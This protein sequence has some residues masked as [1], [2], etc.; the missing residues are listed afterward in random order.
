MTSILTDVKKMIG[1]DENYTQF[2]TDLIIHIN[3][4]LL[5]LSQLG[6]GPPEGFMIEDKT[7]KWSD[8]IVNKYNRLSTVKSFTAMKVKL[9]FDPPLSSSVMESANRIISEFEWRIMIEADSLE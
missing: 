9:L 8:F 7:S 1:I 2:D 5:I 4:V 3:S 6:V